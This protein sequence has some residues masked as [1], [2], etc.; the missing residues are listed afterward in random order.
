MA[1]YMRQNPTTQASSIAWGGVSA[2]V[3]RAITAWGTSDGSRVAARAKA[4]HALSTGSS[5]S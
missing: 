4:R 2:S 3:R 1:L 5:G